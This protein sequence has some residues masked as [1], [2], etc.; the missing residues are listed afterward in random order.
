MQISLIHTIIHNKLEEEELQKIIN[1]NIAKQTN[2][3]QINVNIWNEDKI[4]K[5]LNKFNK[6]YKTYYKKLTLNKSKE[7]FAKYVILQKYGGL[8]IN[9]YLLNY[10]KNYT[11]LNELICEKNKNMIFFEDAKLTEFENYLLQHSDILINDDIIFISESNNDLCDKILKNIEF[12]LPK[13][14]YESQIML[15]NYFLSNI[16]NEYRHNNINELS[17]FEIINDIPINTK[18]KKDLYPNIIDLKNPALSLKEYDNIYEILNY[19]KIFGFLIF[20]FL[21]G[22]IGVILFTIVVSISNY[23]INFYVH[24]M[25]NYKLIKANTNDIVFYNS[26]N[27][28]FEIFNELKNNWK[29]IKTE[30]LSILTDAPKLNIGRKYENWHNSQEYVDKIKNEYGWIKSWKKESTDDVNDKWLNYGLLYFDEY[31]TENIKR[32]PKTHQLLNSIK[33]KI[34]ICGFSYMM[35]NSVIDLHNDETGI[36]NNSLAFHLGLIV[37]KNNES[38]KLVIKND[39]NEYYYVN[40]QEGKIIIFDATYNHY[41]YNQSNEDRV[42]LYI[43]FKID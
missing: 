43:D 18:Y 2:N 29:D 42:I 1:K 31:F 9:N 27:S 16:V 26:K 19:V 15:G 34:N 23:L 17:N 20:Y 37:P 25:V 4:I 8:Y 28:K 10:N 6:K 35:G 14:Q 33:D 32:C 12:N 3:L 39:D 36:V 21:N 40:E 41:A 30:A 7:N 5:L 11:L 22:L 13:N 38:C 24:N